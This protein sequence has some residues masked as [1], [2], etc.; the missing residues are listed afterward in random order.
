MHT[1]YNHILAT[2]WTKTQRHAVTLLQSLRLTRQTEICPQRTPSWHLAPAM[3][4][5][6]IWGGIKQTT[7]NKKEK[8]K[9]ERT[10]CPWWLDGKTKD[11]SYLVQ[12]YPRWSIVCWL[13]SFVYSFTVQTSSHLRIKLT[14]TMSREFIP[15]STFEKRTTRMF[16]CCFMVKTRKENCLVSHKSESFFAPSFFCWIC[17][18]IF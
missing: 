10:Y 4:G 17:R 7:K 2:W 1:R 15:F 12:G 16:R 6:V 9:R 8:N 5:E 3:T 18:A 11:E 14:A 13:Y